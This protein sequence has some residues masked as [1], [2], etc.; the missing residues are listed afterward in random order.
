M[1]FAYYR[2]VTIDKDLV[3]GDQ[4]DFPVLIS[5]TYAY[6]ATVA[7]GGNVENSNGYDIVFY[8]DI[9]C[10][11]KLDHEIES[12]DATTGA[13]VFWVRIPSLSS[14]VDTV[15]YMFYGDAGITVSQEN[16][17]AVWDSNYKLVAHFRDGSTLSMDSYGIVPLTNVGCTAATGKFGGGASFD[18]INDYINGTDAF[19][20]DVLTISAWVNSDDVTTANK[21]IV[22][23]RNSSGISTSTDPEYNFAFGNAGVI[24]YIATNASEVNIYSPNI[25]STTALVINTWYYVCVV[26]R[27]NGN[28]GSIYINGVQDG[29]EPTQTSVLR[30]DTS[31]IQIGVRTADVNTRYFDGLMDEVRISNI[32]RSAGWITTEYNNQSDPA[33]FYSIGSATNA[34]RSLT[35]VT[36][37][38]GITSITF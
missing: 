6:L 1:A 36:S 14:S 30:D 21:T 23:K 33:T 15:I 16:K 35:G 28:I 24:Q 9:N 37:L 11:T 32:A 27:G 10:T 3:S 2:T 26:Q 29:N 12:Y 38:T 17:V 4:T 19:Y 20:S 5:G 22:C 7:N 8:T 31:P 34:I 13:V 25:V 18:G